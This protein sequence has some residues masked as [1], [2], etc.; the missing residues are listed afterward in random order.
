MSRQRIIVLTGAAAAI[1]AIA[2]V[3]FAATGQAEREPVEQDP[4][5]PIVHHLQENPE[6]VQRYWTEE[7]MRDAQPA[8]MPHV[9]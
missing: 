4:G 1:A 3:G 7:R 5:K 6:Q 8:P 9:E 2:I